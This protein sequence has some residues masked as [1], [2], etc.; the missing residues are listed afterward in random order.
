MNISTRIRIIVSDSIIGKVMTEIVQTGK[1]YSGSVT[2][3]L[4]DVTGTSLLIFSS[5]VSVN[6]FDITSSPVLLNS[7]QSSW[8]E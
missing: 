1:S 4:V 8:N 2:V 6:M 7:A 5:F 3:A